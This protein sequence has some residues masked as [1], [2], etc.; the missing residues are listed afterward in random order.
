[1]LIGGFEHAAPLQMLVNAVVYR[2]LSDMTFG[3]QIFGR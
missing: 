3:R 1:M 2:R